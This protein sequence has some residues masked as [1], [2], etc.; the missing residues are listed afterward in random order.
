MTE[1]PKP[2]RTIV[3]TTMSD[4]GNKIYMLKGHSSQLRA[5]RGIVY[6]LIDNEVAMTIN[7]AYF[8]SLDH[9]RLKAT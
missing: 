6:I 4:S 3:I 5:D 2:K 1:Q 8:I 9:G 7:Q